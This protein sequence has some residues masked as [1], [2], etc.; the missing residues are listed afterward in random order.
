M[1]LGEW[2][3]LIAA[4]TIYHLMPPCIVMPTETRSRET[5]KL[6]GGVLVVENGEGLFNYSAPQGLAHFF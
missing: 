5:T 2:Q 4:R 3:P 1:K 6:T